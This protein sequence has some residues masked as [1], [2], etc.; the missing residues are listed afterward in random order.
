M[1]SRVYKTIK[2]IKTAKKPGPFTTDL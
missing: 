1:I 2:I